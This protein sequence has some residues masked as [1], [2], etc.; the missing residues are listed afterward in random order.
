MTEGLV[1][2]HPRIGLELV[3]RDVDGLT[4]CAGGRQ[5]DGLHRPQNGAV[6]VALD[7]DLTFEAHDEGGT[8]RLAHDREDT[9]GRRSRPLRQLDPEP[10]VV[11]GHPVP[12]AAAGEADGRPLAT[13]GGRA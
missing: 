6:V 8:V 1:G 4:Q 7:Q 11:V 12:A 9:V 3:G 13:G 10:V 2:D 5:V